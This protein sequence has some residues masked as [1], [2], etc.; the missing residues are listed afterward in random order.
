M[1]IEPFTLT[2]RHVR[3]QPL[4]ADLAPALLAA[5]NAQRDTF[6][7]THVPATAEVMQQ[8]IDGLLADAARDTAVPFAQVR[9]ADDTPVGCTRFMNVTWWPG[10]DTPVEV[11]I[12]GTWLAAAAQRT[13]INT[14]AKLLLL[15]HA[16]DVWGVARVAICTD[17]RNA[18]SRAAIERLG[19]QFEGILRNHRASMGHATEPGT[20]RDTACY[21]IIPS[22]WPAVRDG[23]LARLDG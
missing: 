17:A 21:S 5:A 10:H 22:E 9:V 15:T 4:T 16:F 12:G 18:R 19:A 11:E 1:R 3:L 13:P 6:G 7:H 8:Y 23:L 20:P 2:G 14:E